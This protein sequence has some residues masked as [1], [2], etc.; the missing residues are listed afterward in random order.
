MISPTSQL[1]F[2]DSLFFFK[3]FN[4]FNLIEKIRFRWIFEDFIDFISIYEKK[5][6]IMGLESLLSIFT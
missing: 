2:F 6:E 5:N 4:R 1:S 3:I